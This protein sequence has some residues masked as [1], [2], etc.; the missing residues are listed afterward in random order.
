MMVQ[1][2]KGPAGRMKR[3]SFRSALPVIPSKSG[4]SPAVTN[5]CQSG[6][7]ALLV[8]SPSGPQMSNCC[9][10]PLSA[11][12]QRI[13][14]PDGNGSGTISIPPVHVPHTGRFR[15]TVATCGFVF[16]TYDPVSP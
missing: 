11:V 3:G 14:S 5:H 2:V 8:R 10:D 15:T 4:N 7:S 9:V 16:V 1:S 12:A 6:C 13:V